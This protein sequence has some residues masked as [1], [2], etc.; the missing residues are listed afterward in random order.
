MV[1]YCDSPNWLQAD[2]KTSDIV[3]LSD[4]LILPVSAL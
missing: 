2:T 3:I 1:H 4:Y